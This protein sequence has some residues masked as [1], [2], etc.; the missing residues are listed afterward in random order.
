VTEAWTDI[1]VD[2]RRA[3]VYGPRIGRLYLLPIEQA[4]DPQ[5]HRVIGLAGVP[6]FDTLAD[7][8]DRI[9]L[10]RTQLNDEAS[11]RASLTLSVLY[12]LLLWSRRLLPL[13]ATARL[14]EAAARCRQPTRIGMSA[15]DIGRLVHQVEARTRIADCYPR[16]L[17][18]AFLCLTSGRGCTLTVGVLAPTRKMHAWCGVEGELPYEP[19]PEHY[20][21]QP[22]WMLVLAR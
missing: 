4:R 22:L 16:A 7:P 13:R 17:L 2:G 14:V 21:Y 12:R 20:L 15:A 18:T 6:R 19:L 1:G 9:V 11:I 3:L 10:D 8:I 5:F